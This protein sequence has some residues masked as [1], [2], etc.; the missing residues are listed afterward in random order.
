M[1]KLYKFFPLLF[2]S[3]DMFILI[4]FDNLEIK[5]QLK[6]LISPKAG[7]I[8]GG[9]GGGGLGFG[10]AEAEKTMRREDFEMLALTYEGSLFAEW[11]LE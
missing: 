1:I 9:I 5:V 7:P 8:L 10:T 6:F 4:W 11:F 2:C 3:V